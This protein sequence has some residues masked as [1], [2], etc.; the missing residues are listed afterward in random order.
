MPGD[1]WV[2][3][4][5]LQD[6]P[7]TCGRSG[8]VRLIVSCIFDGCM[9]LQNPYA[10]IR[11]VQGMPMT[12]GKSGWGKLMASFQS[13]DDM[14]DE[15][16]FCVGCLAPLGGPRVA[17]ALRKASAMPCKPSM[18]LFSDMFR[19]VIFLPVSHH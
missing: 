11:C 13:A 10:A 5:P 6:I 12:G 15:V 9:C 17:A 2:A 7:S 16:N 4:T 1:H 19:S 3:S 8:R 14:L 18:A